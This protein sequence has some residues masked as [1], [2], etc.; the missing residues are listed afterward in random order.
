MANKKIN[1]NGYEYVDLELPSG[2]LWATCNVGASKPSDAGLYFQWGDTKGYTKEQIGNG[3]GQKKFASD[4]SDYKFGV[5]PNYT[6][7]TTPGATLELEDD[8]A[9]ANMGGEWH[10]P[11]PDQIK[12]LIDNTT[13]TWTTQDGVNGRLFT[14]KKDGT[15]SIFIPAAGGAWGGSV[16]SSGDY[17]GVWSS[18]LYTDGVSC[19][20]YL[21]FGSGYVYLY[22][23]KCR[24]YGLSV[25]GVIDK[26]HDNFKEKKSNM[27]D[28]LNLVEILKDAPKGTKLWSPICGDCELERI[29][30]EDKDDV[31]PIECRTIA[32][33]QMCYFTANGHY[34]TIFTGAECVLF[35]SKENRDWSTF[36]VPK[37][38]KEFKPF[39][40]VLV[41]LIM[42]GKQNWTRDV[43]MCYRKDIKGHCTVFESMVPDDLII[44]YDANKDGKPVK[45]K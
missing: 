29:Y 37:K 6:K 7:Y 8:A 30:F 1:N 41:G 15:K 42:N 9:H 44:P 33:E 17:G 40:K 21:G 20:Q 31:V 38:H 23:Y 32:D 34:N 35:P 22:S 14:S 19:G 25:R 11:T 5:Y 12:E 18:L 26:K 3:E 16:R 4:E 39:Q 10:M 13:S 24:C 28:N 2:T 36:K 27:N 45:L 43:Y